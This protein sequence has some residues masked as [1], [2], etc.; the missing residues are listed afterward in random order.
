MHC[1]LVVRGVVR[2][3]PCHLDLPE[4]MLGKLAKPFLKSEEDEINLV[5]DWKSTFQI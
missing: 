3:I 2:D 5:S 4:T 1:I